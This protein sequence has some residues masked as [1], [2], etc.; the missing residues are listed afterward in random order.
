MQIVEFYKIQT[1]LTQNNYY[2]SRD[3][4]TLDL[5]TRLYFRDFSFVVL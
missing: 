4:M 1:D 3:L 2:F 5:F